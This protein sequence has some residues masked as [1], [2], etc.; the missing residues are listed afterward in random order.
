MYG[1]IEIVKLLVTLGA[2]VNS[3]DDH[4]VTPLH[5]AAWH[6]YSDITAYLILKGANVNTTDTLGSSPLKLAKL[7]KQT[8]VVQILTSYGAKE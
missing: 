3:Q 6:G 7:L 1:Q 2:D 5:Q 4:G 8:N